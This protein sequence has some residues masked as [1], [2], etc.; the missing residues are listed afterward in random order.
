MKVS[1]L[2]ECSLVA[3]NVNLLPPAIWTS[4]QLGVRCCG[5]DIL[6]YVKIYLILTLFP[7][8]IHPKCVVAF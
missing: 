6:G 8:S 5:V 1:H 2:E 4:F 3:G 7:L